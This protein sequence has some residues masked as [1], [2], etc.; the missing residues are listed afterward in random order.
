M[1]YVARLTLEQ[2]LR[3]ITGK[4]IMVEGGWSRVPKG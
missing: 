3:G 2:K 4:P 1:K